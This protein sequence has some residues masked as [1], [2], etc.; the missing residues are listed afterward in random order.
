LLGKQHLS[1]HVVRN[2]PAALPRISPVLERIFGNMPIF[3]GKVVREVGKGKVIYFPQDAYPSDPSIRS[4]YEYAL[5]DLGGTAAAAEAAR[6]WIRGSEDVQFAAYDWAGGRLRTLYLLNI[7]WWSGKPS[8]TVQFMLG[9]AR[10][11]VQAP[12]GGISIITAGA[13]LAVMPEGMDADIIDLT[14]D[15]IV[16]QSDAGTRLRLFAP[17][18]KLPEYIEVKDGGVQEIKI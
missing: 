15:R 5:R 12:A 16:V 18:R 1:T 9:D 13:G 3:D 10:Y 14:A 17:E 6:G 11:E 4:A 8:S 2:Q 7:D